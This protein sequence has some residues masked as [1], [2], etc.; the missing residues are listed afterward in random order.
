[1]DFPRS[2]DAIIQIR[3]VRGP[4]LSCSCCGQCCVGGGGGRCGEMCITAAEK[5][6][7]RGPDSQA[8]LDSVCPSKQVL[9]SLIDVL[10][11]M[12]VVELQGKVAG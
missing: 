4:N 5:L 1:M 10:Q 2:K 9:H 12:I 7:C 8:C 3:G 11:Y 6:D